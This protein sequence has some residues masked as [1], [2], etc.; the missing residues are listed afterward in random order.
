MTQEKT[1]R[2][3]AISPGFGKGRCYVYRDILSFETEPYVIDGNEV[4][5]E[6]VRIESALGAVM[7][8]IE[9]TVETLSPGGETQSIEG[10]L[11]AQHAILEDST[12][13]KDLKN[14]ITTELLNAEEVVKTVFRRLEHRLRSMKYALF[15]DRGDDIADLAKRVLQELSGVRVQALQ[16]LPQGSILVAERL[17]P[18]DTVY[19]SRDNVSAI[20]V[21]A[22]GPTCHVAILAREMGLP[23]VSHIKNVCELFKTCDNLLV[24]GVAG[25]VTLHPSE[26][27]EA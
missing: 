23:A 7:H 4:E 17:L 19:L 16:N 24:N 26:D 8:D 1:F 22:G 2:G 3:I 13:R 27:T 21:E 20:V 25:M 12:L 9:E 14:E 6:L 18:S 5:E 11:R 15:R 10:I